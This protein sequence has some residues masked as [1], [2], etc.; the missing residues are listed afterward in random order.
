MYIGYFWKWERLQGKGARSSSQGTGE[1]TV[2]WLFPTHALPFWFVLHLGFLTGPRF[3]QA[4][5]SCNS[6][7]EVINVRWW[8]C[9]G[10]CMRGKAPDSSEALWHSFSFQTL[11]L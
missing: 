10:T 1:N 4:E 2:D 7:R 6:K 11:A 9:P 5:T 8:F 3:C